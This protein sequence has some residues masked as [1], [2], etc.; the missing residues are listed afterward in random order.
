MQADKTPLGP[1]S[2]DRVVIQPYYEQDG[3]TIYHGDCREILPTLDNVDLVL[4][5]PPYGIDF[6]HQPANLFTKTRACV[7]KEYLELQGNDQ[8]FNPSFLLPFG[9]CILWGANHYAH[10]LPHNGKWLIWDKRGDT[11]PTRNQ[12]DCELAWFS[13]YGAARVFRH[14]WDGM[15]KQSERGIPRQ[16]PTQKPIALMKWCIGFAS[17]AKTILDPFMGSGT[18][19]LAAKLECRQAIGIEIEE[20]YCEIAA[21]RL[22]QGVLPFAG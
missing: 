22:R 7:G 4:T 6:M 8:E 18:T 16:H 19:L 10:N 11:Q 14:V 21:N 20:K 9:D 1:T 5:D 3:I 12:A 13:E 17:E 2:F 15:I